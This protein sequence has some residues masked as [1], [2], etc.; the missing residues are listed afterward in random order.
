MAAPVAIVTDS[1]CSIPKEYLEKYKICVIPQILIWEG[2]TL[3]D[4]IDIQVTDFYNRLAQSNSNPTTSQATIASFKKVFDEVL[5]EG[6]DI[7]AIL[8][9]QK[10]SG[11]I[12]SANQAKVLLPDAPIEIVDSNSISMAMGFQILSVAY[13]ASEGASLSECKLLAEKAIPHTGVAIAVDTLE[14]LHRGGRI[15][16]G[17][18]FLGTALN[19]KPILE[20]VDG[21]VEPV[22]RVRTRKKSLSRLV[23]LIA[24]RV[25]DR[26][27]VRLAG[28]H[29]NAPE[30]ARGLLEMAV[31]RLDSVEQ[32][33]TEVSPVVGAHAGPGTVGL[34]Y[35][36]GI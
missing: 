12:E 26:K 8:I 31:G 22:E 28:L 23:D 20:V 33:F 21:R 34:A 14:Y 24:E 30:D 2:E 4:G 32:V 36:A 9:S 10:L 15:G 7:L 17:A 19:I 5:E 29:A 27:P 6:Y 13:A 25:G 35:M 11:T 18:R 16:G 3:L 1:T